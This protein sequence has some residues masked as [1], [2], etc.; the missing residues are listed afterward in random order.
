MQ[1][2]VYGALTYADL[3]RAEL[4]FAP[5]AFQ[6][7]LARMSAELSADVY[8]LS[9]SAW[10][11]AGWVDAQFI[12]RRRVMPLGRDD[13]SAAK[14]VRAEWRQFRAKAQLRGARP[15]GDA[16][17]TVRALLAA[18]MGKSVVMAC[19]LSD[20][21]AVVAVSFLGTTRKLYD[22]LA[23]FHA[24]PDAGVH[25][26]FLAMARQFDAQA[27][28]IPLPGLSGALGLP[29]PTLADAIAAAQN[30]AGRVCLWLSGHSQ[31]G[32]LAQVYARLLMASGVATER[33]RGYTF[34]APRVAL[35]AAPPLP[36]Y[37]LINADD[38]IPRLGAQ[39]RWGNDRIFW[40]DDAF[41]AAHYRIPEELAA[42]FA[43]V[44]W[45]ADAVRTMRDACAW[46]MALLGLVRGMGQSEAAAA[47]VHAMIPKASL[48]GRV[49]IDLPELAQHL[50]TR[51][52]AYSASHTGGAPDEAL[53]A[54]YREGLLA[55]IAEFGAVATARALSACLTA[56]H[57]IRPDQ[58]DETFVPPYASLVRRYLGETIQ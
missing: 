9:L 41:R 46:G 34:G 17:R 28:R 31:G 50:Q 53:M 52:G 35:A 32:A 6:P 56:P 49:G 54:R 4:C 18:D 8:S 57:R 24:Q 19:P 36:I 7:E 14:L 16:V 29:A 15:I 45:H 44:R 51:L 42:V 26:G 39:T 21:R 33:L 48:L 27:A 38:L 58:K 37:N 2:P 1:Q 40:P 30:P 23:N 13:D 22:W 47:F 12:L 43:R 10:R 55:C 11:A 25:A 3:T 5:D 20:G